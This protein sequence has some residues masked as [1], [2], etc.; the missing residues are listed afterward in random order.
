MRE[1]TPIF[2]TH[3]HITRFSHHTLQLD[4]LKL[5]YRLDKT[6]NVTAIWFK[7]SYLFIS[8]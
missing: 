5:T 6:R 1:I 2:Q 4:Y 7:L 8:Y 3:T